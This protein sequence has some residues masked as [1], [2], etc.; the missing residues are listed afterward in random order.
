MGR[1]SDARERLLEAM[2]EL[3]WIGSFGATSVDQICERAEVKK[4]SFYHFFESKHALALAAVEQGWAE[5][6]TRMDE[7]FSAS[8]PPVNR[9]MAWVR[10]LY[11]DQAEMKARHGRV[12]GCP[13]HTLGT[14]LG[15][16]DPI[17]QRVMEEK[18]G[19]Y[20][21]YLE[22]AI[23]DGHAEGALVAP[24]AR[25]KARIVFA[26]SEGLLAQARIWN[27]LAILESLEEGVRDILRL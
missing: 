19:H 16:L 27:D 11:E 2:L 7:A 17:F 25:S 9:L 21:R 3:I 8:L 1:T 6:K 22:S 15:P 20:V 12:L 24:D 5:F 13:M 26:Y 4:G 18:L 10:L 23:R 14:E